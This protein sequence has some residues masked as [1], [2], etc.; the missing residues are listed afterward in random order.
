M[1][2]ISGLKGHKGTFW[3]LE[4]V[5]TYLVWSGDYMGVYNFTEQFKLST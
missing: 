1:R 4:I 5:P 3:V 2:V